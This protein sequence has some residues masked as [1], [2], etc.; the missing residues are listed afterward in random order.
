VSTLR[1]DAHYRRATSAGSVGVW[2][3]NLV[4][5][6][7][8]VDPVLNALLGY[9]E[10]E[11]PNDADNWRRLVHADDAASARERAQA[12][13]RGEA[14]SFE[15]E[16]RMLHRDGSIRWFLARGLVTRD[17]HGTAVSIAGTHIDITD[18]KGS[19]QALHRAEE[20]NRQI[21]AWSRARIDVVPAAL[22]DDSVLYGA[23]ALAKETFS[24]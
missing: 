12:H 13:I 22:A 9:D 23:L 19:E 21:T 2:D 7:L 15:L 4:T 24:K 8:Y 6:E 14:P 18:R 16:Y 1:S 11:I 3:W 17:E 5:G 20:L 10:H